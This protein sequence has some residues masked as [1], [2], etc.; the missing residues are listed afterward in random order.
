MTRRAK[1]WTIFFLA[2][3]ISVGLFRYEIKD[4]C[5]CFVMFL[6]RYESRDG[7]SWS[8]FLRKARNDWWYVNTALRRFDLV[9]DRTAFNFSYLLLWSDLSGVTERMDGA[10]RAGKW[11]G[12]R[13]MAGAAILYHRTGDEKYL[14]HVFDVVVYPDDEERNREFR[15]M[16][17][18]R[19]LHCDLPTHD[20]HGVRYPYPPDESSKLPSSF[21]HTAHKLWLKEQEYRLK[22]ADIDSK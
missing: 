11:S 3:G 21:Y 18:F 4:A 2:A 20:E 1:K 22:I 10:L 8:R 16:N 12:S 7:R 19:A 5:V 6:R 13:E 9:I 17:L 15:R 14:K